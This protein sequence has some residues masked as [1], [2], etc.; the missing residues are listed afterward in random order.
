[1]EAPVSETDPLGP[2]FADAVQ[3]SQAIFRRVLD[4]MAR[5][6]TCHQ[7]PEMPFMPAPLN[8]ASTAIVLT[9]LDD[10]TPVWLD[11]EADSKP[12]R[13]FLSFHCG[14]PIVAEPRQG[15][16]ALIAGTLPPLD[17]FNA[18]TDEFPENS[19]T[20][21]VQVNAV[22][23][24]DDIHLSGPG[25]E[26]VTT[27]GD[28]GLADSFWQQRAEMGVLYPCGVDLIL[29]AAHRLACLPR[30]VHR[31]DLGATTANGGKPN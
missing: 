10:S 13:D 25:I 20:L 18:G 1:M 4:A 6:G 9:L 30:S 26:D 3:Q 15:A 5:P 21:I 31:V 2:G 19:T 22:E 29:T 14:C 23:D 16:F 24:G 17:M 27:I 12:V 28:P 8:A 7:I 11:P